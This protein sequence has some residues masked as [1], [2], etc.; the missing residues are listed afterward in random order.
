MRKISL[1]LIILFLILTFIGFGYDLLS[2]GQINAR[3]SF[4]LI[5]V[6]LGCLAYYRCRKK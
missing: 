4:V 3:Y 6:G 2:H 5:T 1:F